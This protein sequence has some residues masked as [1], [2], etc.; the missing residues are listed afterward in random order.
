MRDH[1]WVE[2]YRPKKL[3][4]CVLPS[5]LRK[6]LEESIAKG[7]IQNMILHGGAGCGKTTVARAICDQMGMDYL[8][9]NASEDSGIDTLRTKIR[10]YASTVSLNDRPK[11]VILDEADYMN[12]TSL[13]PALRGAIEEF[14]SNCRFIFTCNHLSKII[15]PIHSRCAVFDFSLPKKEK[16]EVAKAF[17]SRLKF[18][19]RSEETKFT[20]KI[21]VEVVR[22]FFPDFRRI[23]NECQKYS[24]SGT[25]DAGILSSSFSDEN[26][27]SLVEA[28]KQ[29]NFSSVRKW[30]SENSDKD[31]SLVFRRLYDS[32]YEIL[33]PNSIPPA[34]LCIANYQYRSA[35]CADQEVNLMACCI[36]IM[37]ECEFK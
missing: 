5:E 8:F 15:K 23:I 21:V 36:E 35:F 34:I 11:V 20:D 30:I 28:M 18:I 19:L 37:A 33:S 24:S 10:N 16:A 7:D 14:A 26:L 12:P 13:Q 1:L 29:K 4:D 6:Q 3:E 17:F 2:K 31:S 25:I 22:K 9:V 27:R 32:L